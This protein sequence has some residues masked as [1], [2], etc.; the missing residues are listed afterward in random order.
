MKPVFEKVPKRQWE[1]FHCETVRA[2]DYGTRW[3][4]HP[5]YQLTL[6]IE[7][8]GHR[9]VGDNISALTDGDIVLIGSNLP[10]VWHQDTSA[11][12]RRRGRPRE[13]SGSSTARSRW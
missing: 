8:R 11:K 5:E 6:A 9:V 13:P 10:H 2:L 12:S 7:S 3:H 4:F 1:S